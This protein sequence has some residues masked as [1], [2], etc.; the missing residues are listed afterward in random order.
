MTSTSEYELRDLLN[1]HKIY[2]IFLKLAPLGIC[3]YFVNKCDFPCLIK[4]SEK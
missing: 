3:I 4:F 1:R 2:I